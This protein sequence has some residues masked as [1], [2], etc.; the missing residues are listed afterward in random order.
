MAPQDSG[1]VPLCG[2]YTHTRILGQGPVTSQE[3]GAAVKLAFFSSPTPAGGRRE[4]G[5]GLRAERG[6]WLEQ[7]LGNRP[8]RQGVELSGREAAGW[9]R[10][11]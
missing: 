3:R 2:G 8:C 4:E 11:Q 5:E 1:E 6:V 10:R 9:R 7:L